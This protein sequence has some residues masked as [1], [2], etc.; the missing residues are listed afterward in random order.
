[1]LVKLCCNYCA[2]GSS[3][4]RKFILPS[5]PVTEVPSHIYLASLRIGVACR[6]SINI[7]RAVR[8]IPSTRR[9]INLFYFPLIVC[10]FTKI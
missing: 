10:F 7:V 8:C 2:A 4:M 9:F 3:D 5:L 1:M 6:R